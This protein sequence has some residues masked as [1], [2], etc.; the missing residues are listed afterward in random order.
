VYAI[1][2]AGGKQ[3]KAAPGDIL[4]VDRLQAQVGEVIA[5]G[6]VLL[7]RQEDG[8]TIVGNPSV[9]N[10][11]AYVRVLEHGRAPKIRVFKY[12]PKVNYRR[13]RGHRQPFTKVKV[14]KIEVQ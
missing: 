5:L 8:R 11:T 4:I 9:E 10:A 14:E 13:R 7:L 6:R 2:D 1:V 12:K 3:Y